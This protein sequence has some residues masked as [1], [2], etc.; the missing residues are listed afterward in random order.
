MS[1]NQCTWADTD[2]CTLQLSPL[3]HREEGT[4]EGS[5]N[6]YLCKVQ[7]CPKSCLGSEHW[8]GGDGGGKLHC[9]IFPWMSDRQ[10]SCGEEDVDV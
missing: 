2:L 3:Y 6:M 8:C 1:S 5:R 4:E 7:L 9:F 10:Y